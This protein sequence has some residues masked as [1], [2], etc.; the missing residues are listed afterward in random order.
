MGSK[1]SYVCL[2]PSNIMINIMKV[3]LFSFFIFLCLI[4]TANAQTGRVLPYWVT[5]LPSAGADKNYYYRVTMAE[6]VSYDKAYANAFAKAVMEAKWRMGVEV[7]FQD[8]VKSL[9]N[10]VT[11]GVNVNQDFISIPMNKVCDYWEA[12]HTPMGD[13]IRLYVLWQVAKFGNKEPQFEE[14]TKCQ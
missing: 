9:E 11:E 7:H 13:L 3:R 14:F 10:S 5:Q 2:L 1:Q 8:D 6:D 12:N 4:L